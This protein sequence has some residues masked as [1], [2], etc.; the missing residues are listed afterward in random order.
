MKQI[1]VKNEEN[2]KIATLFEIEEL[3][4]R[5]EFGKW[6]PP[7]NPGLPGPTN[8]NPPIDTQY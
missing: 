6:E 1:N 4:E 2:L 5:V 3:E 8:P 7:T